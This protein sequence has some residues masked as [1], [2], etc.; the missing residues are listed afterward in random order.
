MATPRPGSTRRGTARRPRESGSGGAGR[1]F[2]IRV[3]L[4]VG[5]PEGGRSAGAEEPGASAS[6]PAG[7]E[8]GKPSSGERGGA[9]PSVGISSYNWDGP[10]GE[11]YLLEQKPE[12]AVPTPVPQD[13]RRWARTFGG[14][15]GGHMRLQLTVTGNT[16]ASVVLTAL[17]VRV[18]G[19]KEPLSWQA[20]SMGDGC[21]GGVTP[22]TFDIDLDDARPSVVPKAGQDGDRTVPA[23]DFPY[24][25]STSDPQVLNLD[26]HTEGH[27][28]GWYLELSWS[29]GDKMR[30]DPGRR[31]RVAVPHQC[32]GGP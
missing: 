14:V 5:L 26:V 31:R 20:Y 29:S 11:Y 13:A 16:D 17:D 18:V 8:S 22:Q 32:A 2:T 30:D 19:R 25:V 3:G 1:W 10:C 6:A 4:G 24:K 15:A 12:Q 23:K 9:A 27:E 21:G 7:G 28:V